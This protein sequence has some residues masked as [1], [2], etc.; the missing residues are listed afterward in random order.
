MLS[1]WPFVSWLL[2][3]QSDF[4]IYGKNSPQN[5]LTVK[6]KRLLS[7]PAR[8]LMYW[9]LQKK[10]MVG[11]KFS[12]SSL[13]RGWGSK[14]LKKSAWVVTLC[15]DTWLEHPGSKHLTSDWTSQSVGISKPH[16]LFVLIKIRSVWSAHQRCSWRR[17]PGSEY[18][19]R[20][21][22]SVRQRWDYYQGQHG[23]TQKEVSM[24]LV[25]QKGS[26]SDST[27]YMHRIVTVTAP[28]NV[29]P[30]RGSLTDWISDL[31]MVFLFMEIWNAR[32]G[33]SWREGFRQRWNSDSRKPH[34]RRTKPTKANSVNI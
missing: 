21:T 14:L 2:V 4:K 11:G 29:S 18:H 30:W 22:V 16:T 20:D 17:I 34:V 28:A 1:I 26:I 19:R 33:A 27:S 6:G 31:G 10:F 32:R 8:C 12:S 3:G 9:L 23:H 15:S 5:S 13:I 7:A 25:A 24:I